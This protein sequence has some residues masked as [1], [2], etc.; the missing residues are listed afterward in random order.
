MKGNVNMENKTTYYL[1]LDIGTD[2]VGYAVADSRYTLKKYRGEPMWGAALFD[3]AANAADRRAFRTGR[4]RLDRRQ[5]RVRLLEEMFAAD[6][7]KID[8]DFFIRRRESALFAE[9]ASH[10]V[11]IFCGGGMTDQEY[12]KRYPTIHHLIQELMES[13]EEHDIRLVYLACAWLVA[14]RGH[15]L[16]DIASDNIR[17]IL[18]FESTYQNFLDFLQDCD[19][20]LPWSAETEAKQILKILQAACGVREKCERFKAELFGGK[21]SK[22]ISDAFPYS[23]E[24]VI[25]L[26]SGGK[27]KP[28]EL[29]GNDAYA[30]MDSVSLVMNDEDF[31]RIVSELGDDGAFLEQLRRLTDCAQLN[32]VMQDAQSI[33]AA[34]VQVYEQHRSDLR[35]LK[36]LVKTYCPEKYNDI[37]RGDKKDNYLYYS[38][39]IKSLRGSESPKEKFCGKEDFCKF[40]HKQLKDMS[41]SDADKPAYEDMMLRLQLRTFLPK[42]KETDN[43][44]IPQQLYFSELT[45]ILDHAQN[46]TPLLQRT[47][48]DGIAVC[49]KIRSIFR[50]RIPYYV[51][52]LKSGGENAWVVRKAEGKIYP[53]NFSAMVDLDESEKKFIDRMTN[54]CT[55]LSGEDV[56]PECSL[57]YEKYK[58]LNELNNLKINE[59]KLLPAV[60][61]ELYTQVFEKT[62]RVSA[63][64]IQ[65]YLIQ[66]GYMEKT[67][68]L[69]GFDQ[70]VKSGLN[71]HRAFKRLLDSGM[72]S[73]QE[74]EEIIEHRAYTEDKSRMRRWLKTRFPHMADEDVTYILRQNLKGFGRLSRRFLLGVCGTAKGSDGEAHTI[75]DYLWETNENLMQLLSDR[76]TFTETIDEINRAYYAEN[77]M[78]LDK[79]LDEMYVSNAVKRPIF[80][81]LDVVR[82]VEKA[83]GCA[84]AKIFVEMARGGKPEQ[85]G[86]R[87]QSRKEQLLA[88]YRQIKT[89]DARRLAE[90]L[91][92]MGSMADNRLQDRRLFLYYLQLGKCLYTGRPIELARLSDGGVYNLDHIY[93]QCFV[94]DDSLLNNLALVDS[95]ENGRKQDTYPVS[96]EIRQKMR[97]FWEC[98]KKN[99]LMTEE[100]Y[101]RLTRDTPFTDDEKWQFINRQLVE[102]RQSTKV[103]A[104]LLQEHFPD[105]E[106]VYVKAGMV[107]EFRQ[108]FDLPKCRAV[109]D[110]HHAKDAYLN[111]VVGN[112]Y[113]ERFTKKWFSIYKPYNVQVKKLF[114]HAL[115]NG[116]GDY[117]R[118]EEDLALI[119]KTMQKN[120][121]HLTKYAFCRKGG[122]FDQQ[123]VRKKAGL[124][125]LKAGL[126]TEKY[127]G[128]NKPTA[129]FFVLARYAVKKGHEVMFVPIALLDADRFLA[130]PVWA[131]QCTAETMA[132][133]LGKP[134]QDM[135]LLLQGRPLKINTVISIDG[136]RMTLSG[137]SNGGRKILLS[138]LEALM[139]GI[140]AE[141][142]IKAMESF[143]NK[144]GTNPSIQPDER[145][146]GLSRQGNLRIYDLLTEKLRKFPYSK[147]PGNQSDLLAAEDARNRFAGA[148]I[149]AQIDCLLGLIRL[150]SGKANT[151]DLTAAGGASHAGAVALSSSLSNWA[152]KYKSVRIVDASASGL[153]SSSG[154]NL[155]EW[156]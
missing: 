144:R 33:S 154:S 155:L 152:K 142:Y 129:S 118:G 52:P 66:H 42:Q 149:V 150:M 97:P 67:D 24:A 137:K 109:N 43:R 117:W 54:R 40:L 79:R 28:K 80:R 113:H 36:R 123:P 64:K 4:R 136:A 132:E 121:V 65:S 15:F 61:Q 110:L 105:T 48:A 98:L 10:G 143:Q 59:H 11:Q 60:K 102:T 78:S 30:E 14:N 140:E 153:F 88:L 20:A 86:K 134:P 2:S 46:Y 13:D 141:K 124:I 16:L 77:P 47:D 27:V 148:D 87:T 108:E 138:P 6:I 26:L 94:K 119:R 126:P 104:A 107:S 83:M 85:K 22:E 100:K 72:L 111:I 23:V 130:D 75:M 38:H 17:D 18:N 116:D 156:L 91:Q 93:P 21:I 44:I 29:Y 125:P 19:Y 9:D 57:L 103:I 139:P 35:L 145:H 5:Q 58:V 96:A 62:A 115:Q 3:P 114:I 112:V 133:I 69:G 56:L 147:L 1:G 92:G 70:T 128:Y 76:Y 31:A 95:N 122:F 55:Y 68:K 89:D 82:D 7:G 39:N 25:S 151:C 90:E 127:G 32:S 74:V 99:G 53:W 131:R 12:H 120:A 81:T 50:F 84:P 101:R 135:E 146:D 37:F 51:G 49:E 45:A 71:S 73:G 106:I 8:P 41:V 34:K 63:A